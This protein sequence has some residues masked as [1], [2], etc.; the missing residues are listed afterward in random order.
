MALYPGALR[1]VRGRGAVAVVGGL[2]VATTGAVVAF[3]R[4]HAAS[5][6]AADDRVSSV[7]AEIAPRTVG[8]SGGAAEVTRTSSSAVT[9]SGA[10]S[11]AVRRTG[12]AP[13]AGSPKAGDVRTALPGAAAA[14]DLLVATVHTTAASTVRMAG[15]TRAYD[16]VDGAG[17]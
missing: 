1:R 13:S 4:W 16:T 9:L 7:A 5:P 17:T 3:D 15:W 8:C 6:A 11:T 2:F 12:D 14:G 10:G